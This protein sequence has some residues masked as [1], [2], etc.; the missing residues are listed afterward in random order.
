MN[1]ECDDHEVYS[2]SFSCLMEL[3]YILVS[4]HVVS[5]H[6]PCT[7]VCCVLSHA[8]CGRHW[9]VVFCCVVCLGVVQVAPGMLIT[10][11]QKGLAY[12]G[13]EE[14]LNEVCMQNKS[15]KILLLCTCYQATLAA[16]AL[17]PYLL[18]SMPS[19]PMHRRLC[20]RWLHDVKNCNLV[21]IF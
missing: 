10:F 2:L 15:G 4:C 9:C 17:L 11:L 16:V 1:E 7:R 20:R 5:S 8:T 13:I 18:P 19:T 12:V 6:A 3:R 14:H 21:C